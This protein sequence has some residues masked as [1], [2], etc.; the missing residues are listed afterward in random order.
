MNGTFAL[1]A[2]ERAPVDSVSG[3]FVAECRLTIFTN[4][5]VLAGTV[6]SQDRERS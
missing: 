3:S 2:L 5:T 1:A 6:V 4:G